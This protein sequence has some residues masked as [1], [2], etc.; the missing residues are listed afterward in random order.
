MLSVVSPAQ[1]NLRKTRNADDECQVVEVLERYSPQLVQINHTPLQNLQHLGLLS[2][3]CS[4]WLSEM[5]TR[6]TARRHSVWPA[7]LDRS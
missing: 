1:Q 6:S 4:S 3:S 2:T 7:E 5:Y